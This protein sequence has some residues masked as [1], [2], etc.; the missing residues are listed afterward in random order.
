[1][2]TCYCGM[3]KAKTLDVV[4][5]RLISFS[6]LKIVIKLLIFYLFYSSALT[7]SLNILS[8]RDLPSSTHISFPVISREPTAQLLTHACNFMLVFVSMPVDTAAQQI[9]LLLCIHS[10]HDSI[11]NVRCL[12]AKFVS[13]T[14]EN[15][16]QL[17]TVIFTVICG[18]LRYRF[19]I[20]DISICS[21]ANNGFS[22]FHNVSSR[23]AFLG[24][25]SPSSSHFLPRDQRT[26][27]LRHQSL[28]AFPRHG[29]CFCPA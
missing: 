16:E 29:P 18:H 17:F 2:I 3:M 12:Q 11:T 4:V 27:S 14:S 20:G 13:F 22:Y 5:Q 23:V 9:L 10:L 8:A 28:C 6:Y 24:S 26:F 21:Y 7:H 19:I 15:C 25:S 1:M